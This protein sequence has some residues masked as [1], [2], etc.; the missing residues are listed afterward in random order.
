MP[1]YGMQ[2]V[3]YFMIDY[4]GVVA[5]AVGFNMAMSKVIGCTAL[6]VTWWLNNAI[7]MGITGLAPIAVLPLLGVMDA[8]EVSQIYFSNGI[9]ICWSTILMASAVE[10]YKLN[11]RVATT[12][13]QFTSST[14]DGG[15]S[16][17]CSFIAITGFLSMWLSNTA[18]AAL[19]LPLSAATIAQL[20]KTAPPHMNQEGILR[21]ACAIDLGIA[22]S[23]S[24]G[25]TAT[26][27]GTGSNLVL[28]GAM[29]SQFGEA[30]QVTFFQWFAIAAPLAAVNLFILWLILV[31]LFTSACFSSSGVASMTSRWL[32]K[33]P[34][35]SQITNGSTHNILSSDS[36]EQT[37]TDDADRGLE[38]DGG[39]G[40]YELGLSTDGGESMRRC[41]Q[42]GGNHRPIPV[43]KEGAKPALLNED[44]SRRSPAITYPEVV[45]VIVTIEHFDCLGQSS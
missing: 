36:N 2:H 25:G 41:G 10:K 14:T 9:V 30:D 22:F 32:L 28:Q 33:M 21:L 7:P 38:I 43:E 20:K 12:L 6:M 4:I 24:I 26:I 1:R 44:L 17:I 40:L 18:T 5:Y 45:V 19:M 42:G 37:T 15:R 29:L 34:F 31:A 8:S 39:L 13:L 3:S 35:Y 23:S 27:T 11:G 16:I